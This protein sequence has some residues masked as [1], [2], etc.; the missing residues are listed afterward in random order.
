MSGHNFPNSQ[1]QNPPGFTGTNLYIFIDTFP[2]Q[3][4]I[5]LTAGLSDLHLV[6]GSV[7]YE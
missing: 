3:V 1:G 5:C 2:S 4:Y 6:Q 7:T